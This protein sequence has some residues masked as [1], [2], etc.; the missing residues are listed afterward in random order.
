[1]GNLVRMQQTLNAWQPQPGREDLRGFEWHYLQ[2]LLHRERLLLPMFDSREVSFVGNSRL[3]VRRADGKSELRAPETGQLIRELVQPDNALDTQQDLLLVRAAG[4]NCVE[5]IAWT[6]RSVLLTFSEPSRDIQTAWPSGQMIFTGHAD[7]TVKMRVPPD[8]RVAVVMKGEPL[9]VVKGSTLTDARRMWTLLGDGR[10]LFT[11]AGRELRAFDAETGRAL[12]RRS[13]LN[14]LFLGFNFSPD[15]RLLAV[16]CSDRTTKIYELPSLKLRAAFTGHTD[17]VH[18]AIIADDGRLLATA[19]SGRTARLWDIVTA[20]QLAVVRGHT[21][22][23]RSAFFSPDGRSLLTNS[24]DRT[25]RLWSLAELLIPDALTGHADNV[26]TVAFSPD[27]K[28]VGRGR[29]ALAHD[30]QRTC[31]LGLLHSVRARR[32][33]ARHGRA[34]HAGDLVECVHR[35]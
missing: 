19:S 34:G 27:G 33:N 26:F 29:G 28:A 18:T 21:D 35:P 5:A 1:M 7:R 2:R 10:Y 12:G 24:R 4:G 3:L 8:G 22:K 13:E 30:T 32:P 6:D 15:G 11:I 9:P 25:V 23:V 16:G 14:S 31:G 20:R 17:W